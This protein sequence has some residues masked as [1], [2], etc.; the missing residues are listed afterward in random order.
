MIQTYG[1]ALR[2]A[3]IRIIKKPNKTI[4]ISTIPDISVYMCHCA[5]QNLH[6]VYNKNIEATLQV[7]IA[8]TSRLPQN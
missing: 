5:I 6:M 3:W 8:S 4:Y 7:H 1:E 2:F